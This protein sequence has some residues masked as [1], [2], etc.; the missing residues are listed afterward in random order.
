MTEFGMTDRRHHRRHHRP[1]SFTPVFVPQSQVEPEPALSSE[2][3]SAVEA[4]R[5]AMLIRVWPK[6]HMPTP[7][8]T[9][10]PAVYFPAVTLLQIP[11]SL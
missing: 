8:V 5:R 9:S 6:T 2:T 3:A 1:R 4:V 7:S 11:P 10:G